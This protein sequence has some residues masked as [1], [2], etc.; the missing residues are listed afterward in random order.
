M[1][2]GDFKLTVPHLMPSGEEVPRFIARFKQW[3]GPA[4]ED[5]WNGKPTLDF[6]GVPQW[7][8]FAVLLSLTAGWEGYA[9]E[10]YGGLRFWKTSPFHPPD[11]R[12]TLEPPAHLRDFLERVAR[13]N[14]G[15]VKLRYGGC[16]DLLA[17][18][19]D[20]YRF[21]EVKRH[22]RDAVRNTQYQWFDSARRAG[23]S[24]SSFVIVEWIFDS[25]PPPVFLPTHAVTRKLPLRPDIQANTPV[26]VHAKRD[27][28]PP[29]PRAIVRGNSGWDEDSFFSDLEARTDPETTTFIRKLYQWSQSSA[30]RID[31]GA[32]KQ[33][34]SFI[35]RF[36]SCGARRSFFNVETRGWLWMSLAPQPFFQEAATR[37]TLLS[38]V[39]SM[40]ILGGAPQSRIQ[41]QWFA[42]DLNGIDTLAMQERLMRFM[43][44]ILEQLLREGH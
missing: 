44:W 15:N 14:G 13:A 24:A 25:D 39:D 33:Y 43:A 31:W 7:G 12:T 20:E 10:C 1:F 18:R 41:Q 42:I 26:I 35:P 22:R 3:R 29:L 37:Q 17:W 11:R 30:T 4:V 23:V 5:T 21:I 34:G 27:N 32:G 38:W 36:R 28:P 19:G 8:E 40:P 16:W 6:E 9:V 2:R